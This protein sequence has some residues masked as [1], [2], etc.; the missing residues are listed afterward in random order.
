MY[1]R[2][3]GSFLVAGLLAVSGPHAL[4]QEV[5]TDAPLILPDLVVTG[6]LQERTVQ[7]SQTSVVI[8]PG[9][10]LDQRDDFDLYDIIERTPNVVGSGGEKG[11]SIRGIDQRGPASGGTGLLINTQID[12]A[13]LPTVFSAIFGPYS[14]WDLEQVE[15]LRGPQSTQQGRNA[16]AGAVVIRSADPTYDFEFKG[17]GELG[18]RDTIGGALAV[19]VPLIDDTAAVR[20]SFERAQTDGFIDNPVRDTNEYDA[21]EQTTLRAKARLDPT[22]D[23]SAILSLSYAENFGG[24]DFIE[25]SLFPGERINLSDVE[26]QEGSDHLIGNLRMTYDIAEDL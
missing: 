24:E 26:G 23:F 10:E 12:G 18:N 15:I 1:Q 16:L 14:T 9:A 20:F 21:R 8:L 7:D 5:E 25:A 2:L 13:S 3:H 22:E 11:F 4:G 6:E 19:N 17:R